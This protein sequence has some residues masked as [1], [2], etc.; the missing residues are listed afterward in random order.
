MRTEMTF[1]PEDLE[2]GRCTDCN[3][4]CAVVKNDGRCPDCIFDQ[5]FYEQTMMEDHE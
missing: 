1:S 4:E 2:H 5:Y 3:E